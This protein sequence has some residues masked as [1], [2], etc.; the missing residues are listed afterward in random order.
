VA[1]GRADRG[2]GDGASRNKVTGGILP[3]ALIILALSSG[4]FLVSLPVFADVPVSVTA[5]AF[6][7]ENSRVRTFKVTV[8]KD[9]VTFDKEA[10]PLGEMREENATTEESESDTVGT[11]HGR[12]FTLKSGPRVQV[13][14]DKKGSINIEIGDEYYEEGKDIVKFGESVEVEKDRIVDGDVVVIGGSLTIWGTVKGDAVCLGGTLTVCST[15]V[16]EGDAVSMG[17]SVVQEPGAKIMGDEVSM[18]DFVP[19]WIFKGPWPKYGIGFAGLTLLFMK[20]LIVLLITWIVAMVLGDRVKITADTAA[21]KPL[22]SFGLGLLIFLLTPIAMVLLCITVI[23]IPVAILLPIG[24]VIISFL[25]YTG[26]GYAFGRKLFGSPTAGIAKAAIIGILILEALPLVGKLLCIPGGPLCLIGVPIRIVGYAVVGCAVA[27]GLGAAVLSKLGQP[28]RQ[29]PVWI[30]QAGPHGQP[31]W[32]PPRPGHT[33]P[34]GFVPPGRTPLGT[35]P[36]PGTTPPGTG[37]M[38]GPG[39]TP[40]PGSPPIT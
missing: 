32:Q 24:L 11:G 27:M 8:E 15:G 1:D 35:P 40:P 12:V 36:G 21:K 2:R 30:P 10:V 37:P 14:K 13:D 18:G 25:G 22:A 4:V 3:L 28:P 23:G 38:P 9:T 26:I 29:Y 31:G 34:P 20:A 16:V 19:G 5:R 39:R 17:G 6:D 33:P 7:E